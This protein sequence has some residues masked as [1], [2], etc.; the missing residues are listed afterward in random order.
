M[1]GAKIIVIGAA[2]NLFINELKKNVRAY[3][4][5]L[6]IITFSSTT[7]IKVPCTCT[8]NLG[9]VNLALSAGSYLWMTISLATDLINEQKQKHVCLVTDGYKV[10]AVV[11]TDGNPLGGQMHE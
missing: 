8:V 6:C 7:V 1:E 9:L 3:D 2:I 11:L 5:D 4:V 10:S